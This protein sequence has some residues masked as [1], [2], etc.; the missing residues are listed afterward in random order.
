M[1]L[2]VQGQVSLAMAGSESC[3]F[4]FSFYRFDID[5]LGQLGFVLTELMKEKVTAVEFFPDAPMPHLPIS[6]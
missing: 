4:H 3:G 6:G 2:L 5:G 1:R